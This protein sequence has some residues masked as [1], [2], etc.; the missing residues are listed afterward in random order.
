MSAPKHT[1]VRRF[2]ALDSLRLR[3]SY[4]NARPTSE[5]SLFVVP[6]FLLFAFSRAGLAGAA[7][8]V[9]R[10]KFAEYH[11]IGAARF[12]YQTTDEERHFPRRRAVFFRAR[13][14]NRPRFTKTGNERSTGWIS[15]R[16]L[17]TAH[18]PIYGKFYSHRPPMIILYS[19]SRSL[20][21]GRA[22][23]IDN[24]LYRAH[25]ARAFVN[26]SLGDY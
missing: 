7:E 21:T 8:Y 12:N 15:R 2:L 18:G 25:L 24:L 9:A 5:L 11:R 3:R 13:S 4:K 23:R 14:I 16:A 19:L 20:M 6:T 10:G 17:F 26:A 1:I 22:R